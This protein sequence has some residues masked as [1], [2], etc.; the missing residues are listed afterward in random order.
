MKVNSIFSSFSCVVVLL[1]ASVASAQGQFRFSFAASPIQP[2]PDLGPTQS[3]FDVLAFD[4]IENDGPTWP[5]G[6]LADQTGLAGSITRGTYFCR[7]EQLDGGVTSGAQGW[8]MGFSVTGCNGVILA[9]TST[10][11]DIA[12]GTIADCEKGPANGGFDVTEITAG[13]GNE[14]VVHTI[15]LHLKKGT[16]LDP[17]GSN[18]KPALGPEENPATVCRFLLESQNP[19]TAGGT[20]DMALAFTDGLSGSGQP[21][22]NKV[23]Q[24]G[25]SVVPLLVNEI[26]RKTTPEVPQGQFRFSFAGSPAQ[27]APDLGPTQSISDALAFDCIENDGPTWPAGS[28]ADQTGPAS[29]TTRGTYF[30]TIEQLDAGVTSGAQGWQ[31]GFS[32]TGCSGVILAATATQTDIAPG[33]VADCEGGPGQSGGFD[34]TEITTGS[35]NAGAVSALV[36]HL[37]KGTTLDPTGSNTQPATGPELNPATVCRFL[38][39]SQNPATGSD[40]CD[41]TLAFTDGLSGSGQPLENKVTQNGQSVVPAVVSEVIRKTATVELPA[42]TFK[43]AEPV[44]DVSVCDQLALRVALSNSCAVSGFSFG[45]SHDGSVLRALEA[46]PSGVTTSLRS[47][48]GPEYWFMH[49]DPL[50]TDCSATA[51]VVVAMISTF[52]NPFS[53][54]IPVGEDQEIATITYEP[55]AGVAQGSETS[56]E[57]VDCLRPAQDTE[58]TRMTVTCSGASRLTVAES[59]TVRI[60]GGGC[61]QRGDCNRD[62]QFDIS[63]PITGLAYV[64]AQEQLVVPVT[65]LDACDA[66]DDG[67]VDISDAVRQLARLFSGSL[68]LPVPFAECGVD[69]TEDLLNCESFPPCEI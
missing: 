49:V 57:F 44:S 45:V 56:L 4:C 59:G 64:F 17:T 26:I 9:A 5:A 50:V 58:R 67:E 24:A 8:Q 32:V 53:Q 18:V 62:G 47:G 65:C 69:E 55:A 35:G 38:L 61:F 14:G 68:P 41:M 60:G 46:T 29:G 40:T 23:T 6:S 12:P 19:G 20:C 16:T 15:V 48:Q 13:A 2:A 54:T 42:A 36:L 25:Q 22:E 43:F 30:C 28:L 1:T 11:T 34:T 3:A 31:V 63:D 33:T 39:E 66:N 7:V 27:P 10:Q 37:K 21:I 51:G 52:G